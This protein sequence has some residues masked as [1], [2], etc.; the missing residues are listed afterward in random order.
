MIT[1]PRHICP[2]GETFRYIKNY[3]Q[4]VNNCDLEIKE[5]SDDHVSRYNKKPNLLK[6][7]KDNQ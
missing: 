2:C 4:H 6:E 5:E 3:N 1:I 7:G